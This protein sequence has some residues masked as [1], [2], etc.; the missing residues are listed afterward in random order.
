MR[1]YT[2]TGDNGQTGLS[3]GDRV[4]KDD[5]RVECYGTVDELNS[6]L[7]V[8]RAEGLSADVDELCQYLQNNLFVLGA[9]LATLPEKAE[10][11]KRRRIDE[12]HIRTLEQAI[13]R[14]S[15]ELPPLTQFIL[16]GGRKT[17][18]LFHLARTVCRRAERQVVT[19]GKRSVVSPYVLVYLNR[20]SD[21]CFTLARSENH[22]G[23]T[24]D[25]PWR[26]EL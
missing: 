6:C 11:T 17:A 10:Q 19:L 2:K 16:P 13:D 9:E 3:G 15:A 14:F 22:H 18:A 4:D 20:L 21:L 23:Q 5:L 7:G 1:I 25:I 24:P 26:P 8:V 12:S